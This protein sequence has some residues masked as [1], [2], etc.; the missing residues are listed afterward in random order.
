MEDVLDFEDLPFAIDLLDKT[1]LAESSTPVSQGSS[2]ENLFVLSIDQMPDS[3]HAVSP[4][5]QLQPMMHDRCQV[6]IVSQHSFAGLELPLF[7]FLG[8]ESQ[9]RV[10]CLFFQKVLS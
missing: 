1:H 2:H 6:D 3:S 8:T 4:A 9:P 5:S 7:L 10:H